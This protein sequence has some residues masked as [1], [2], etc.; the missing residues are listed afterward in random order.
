MNDE[1]PLY[2]L[3]TCC[4][5]RLVLSELALVEKSPLA[6]LSKRGGLAM[7]FGFP[8]SVDNLLLV[9]SPGVSSSV[10]SPRNSLRPFS[11]D[12]KF[13]KTATPLVNHAPS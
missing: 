2:L 10:P 5:F 9:D 13:G 3:T 7:Y 6:P 4:L 8:L 11:P 1:I 12:Q